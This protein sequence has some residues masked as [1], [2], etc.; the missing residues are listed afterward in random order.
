[1]TEEIDIILGMPKEEFKEAA[2]TAAIMSIFSF[3]MIFVSMI[4]RHYVQEKI[5]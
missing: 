3:G 4:V 2:V 1:M 5:T